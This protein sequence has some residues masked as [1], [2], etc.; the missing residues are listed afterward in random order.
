MKIIYNYYLVLFI[1]FIFTVN[2]QTRPSPGLYSQTNP[3]GNTCSQPIYIC[4]NYS[5]ATIPNNAAGQTPACFSS[6]PQQDIWFAFGIVSPGVLAWKGMPND[7]VTE[8]DWA[9]WDITFGCPGTLMCCNFNYC[10]GSKLGFGMQAQSGTVACNYAGVAT[11][12][13]EF[14]APISVVSGKKYGLQLSNYT[15]NN[16]GFSLTFTNSTCQISC[17]V[18]LHENST[19][20]NISIYPSPNNG[21]FSVEMA[22]TSHP[23]KI[24]ILNSLGQLIYS[25]ALISE[26]PTLQKTL[27]L[28][29][30][31]KG[32]YSVVIQ[33]DS[34]KVVRKIIIE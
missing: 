26:G 4:G 12:L 19:I 7:T 23:I 31:H 17:M 8:Y 3:P 30:N 29:G 28:R 11:K 18:G 24:T 2:S 21:V 16:V 32:V 22:A 14:C 20:E 6:P 34:Y 15:N 1:G 33:S 9:L 13:Q 27:N 5:T 25:D 10:G